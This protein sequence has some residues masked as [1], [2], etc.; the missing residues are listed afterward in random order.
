MVITPDRDE[1]RESDNRRTGSRWSCAVSV[2]SN[3]CSTCF[4]MPIRRTRE[5]FSRRA[6]RWPTALHADQTQH[7][8]MTPTNWHHSNHTAGSI[9]QREP[10]VVSEKPLR[11]IADEGSLE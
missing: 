3:I 5:G 11:W 9:D 4:T 1:A 10:V 7:G 8:G 2:C 6:Q